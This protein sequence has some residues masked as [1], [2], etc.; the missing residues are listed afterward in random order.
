MLGQEFSTNIEYPNFGFEIL[1][2]DAGSFA[3]LGKLIT[4]HGAIE[5]PNFIFVGTKAS[6]KN[7][8]PVQMKEAGADMVLA[9]TY[10]LYIQPGP[11]LVEKMGGLHKFMGW[12][13]PMLTDSGGF[14]I[15]SLGTGGGEDEIKGKGK[16]GNKSLI[17]IDEEQGAIFKSYKDGSLCRLNPEISMEVQRK[18]GADFVVQMD[19][20]TPVAGGR[21]YTENSMRM[22]HRWGDR[23]LQ[24]FEKTHNGMQAVYGVVQGGVYRDLREE[25]ADYTRSRPFFGTA[26]GGCLGGTKVHFY[27]ILSWIPNRIHPDR[28]VHLLGIGKIEDIFEGVKQGMDT[29]DCVTPTREARHGRALMKGVPNGFINLRNSKFKDDGT[30]L[31]ET[32]GLASSANYSKAYIHHLMKAGEMLAFQILSQHNVAVI[33]RLMREIRETLRNGGDL[34]QLRK[35][36]LPT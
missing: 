6:V 35:E 15:F 18:L 34:D 17:K 7:L 8:H 32:L 31:D 12:N 14:Q 10:H 25:S 26:V 11:D 28:P 33:A 1:Q 36:W 29:F 4:P 16:S 30:A 20:C 27:E 13:G 9:N 19:E 22:S 21:E 3:R 23:S 5:T 2:R 24:A